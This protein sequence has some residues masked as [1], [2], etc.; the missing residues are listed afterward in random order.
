[1]PNQAVTSLRRGLV[2]CQAVGP[3]VW[4]P[5]ARRKEITAVRTS[6]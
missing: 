3:P 4:L 5:L 1:V 6:R 2:L